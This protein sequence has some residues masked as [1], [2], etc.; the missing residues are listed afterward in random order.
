MEYQTG[1]HLN[2][3]ESRANELLSN[4]VKMGHLGAREWEKNLSEGKDLMKYFANQYI[5]KSNLKRNDPCNCGSG[6]KYKK[7]CMKEPSYSVPELVKKN[8]SFM[9]PFNKK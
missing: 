6:K 2:K 9:P 4:A 1:D 5:D 8:Q 3:D 7:C